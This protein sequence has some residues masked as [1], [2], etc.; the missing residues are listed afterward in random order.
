MGG[1]V[2]FP[3]SVPRPAEGDQQGDA[4]RKREK[5][6]EDLY[7]RKQE[8]AK[9]DALKKEI[10]TKEKDLADAKKRAE[11]MGKAGSK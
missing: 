4:F 5:A 10:E 1:I 3:S 8:K 7:V 11:E 2:P 6:N 9:L